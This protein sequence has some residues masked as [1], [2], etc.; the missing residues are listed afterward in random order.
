MAV[1]SRVQGRQR[2]GVTAQDGT[3]ELSR[4]G[5]LACSSFAFWVARD[6]VFGD[7]SGELGELG[8]LE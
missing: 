5:R 2:G 3:N 4:L 7:D 1:V 8:E 6:G